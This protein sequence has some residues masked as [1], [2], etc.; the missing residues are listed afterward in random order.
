M[1]KPL[2]ED[3]GKEVSWSYFATSHGKGVVDGIGGSSKRIIRKEVR[4]KSRIVIH[5]I[6]VALATN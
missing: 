2:R 4:A 3:L 1:V 5:S 6:D